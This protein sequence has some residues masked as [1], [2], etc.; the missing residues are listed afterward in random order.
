MGACEKG[1]K[2]KNYLIDYAKAGN[3]LEPWYLDLNPNGYVPT[4]L[5]GPNNKPIIESK[6]IIKYMEDNFKGTTNLLPNDQK[7]IERY[8]LFDEMHENWKT[9]AF[10]FGTM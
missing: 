2:W 1:L 5:V 4:M 3:N 9:E 7:K 8:K 10:T 6:D